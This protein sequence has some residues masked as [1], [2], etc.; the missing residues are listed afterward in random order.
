MPINSLD[1]YLSENVQA[2]TFRFRQ[3]SNNAVAVAMDYFNAELLQTIAYLKRL[4]LVI[5]TKR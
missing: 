2:F 5:H 3:C 1:K 4:K